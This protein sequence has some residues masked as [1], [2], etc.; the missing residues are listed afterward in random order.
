MKLADEDSAATVAGDAPIKQKAKPLADVAD[1]IRERLARKPVFE[2]REEAMKRAE[3]VL[4]NYQADHLRW[5]TSGAKPEEKPLLPNFAEIAESSGMEFRET[6]MVGP[7]ELQKSDLGKVQFLIN[8][9]TPGG[10]PR[11][12][13]QLVSNKI[14]RDFAR[15]RDF[16]PVLVNELGNFNGYIYWISEREEDRVPTLEEAKPAIAKFWK[17]TQAIALAE[18]AAAKMAA[19]ANEKGQRLTSLYPDDAAPTGEFVWFRPGVQAMSTYGTPFGVDNAAEEF[20]SRAFGLE[21]DQA[22]VAANESRKTVYVIQRITEP[23]SIAESGEEYLKEKYFRFKRV[24]T[25]V[26]GGVFVYA[27]EADDKWNEEFVK[28]MG[29]RRVEY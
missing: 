3:L 24:P 28:S 27:Q 10:A 7:E 1:K 18:E 22:G 26:I 25:E 17:S 19:E 5:E 29:Y 12:L 20:M 13:P 23:K 15:S 9:Q 4:E 14:Y 6:G 8:M 2:K 16:D 11:F 21:L